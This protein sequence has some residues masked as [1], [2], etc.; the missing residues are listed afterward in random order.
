MAEHKAGRRGVGHRLRLLLE[1]QNG[2]ETNDQ[3][4][5][6]RC[7]ISARMPSRPHRSSI[8]PQRASPKALNQ[9]ASQ[10]RIGQQ[11]PDRFQQKQQQ[12][13]QPPPLPRQPPPPQRQAAQPNNF[14]QVP[15]HIV[16]DIV[17]T[18]LQNQGITNP[19]DDSLDRAMQEYYS[20]NPQGVSCAN[21]E[22]LT[23]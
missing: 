18:V 3:R 7:C 10:F 9:H 16:K 22:D 15:Q 19:T 1:P 23:Q 6:L 14:Y 12:Q 4:A 21:C 13:Q 20:K 5:R 17:I 8:T 2:M 11:Q